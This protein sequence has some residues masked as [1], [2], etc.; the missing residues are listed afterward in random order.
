MG[1]GI[2]SKITAGDKVTWRDRSISGIDSDTGKPITYTPATHSLQYVIKGPDSDSLT[3]AAVVDGQEWVTTIAAAQS[4]QLSAGLYFWSAGV[5][6]GSGDRVTIQTGQIKVAVNLATI[7]APYDGRSNSRKMLEAVDAAIQARLSGGAVD[8]YTIKGR[9]ASRTPIPDLIRLRDLLK[10][11]VAREDQAA[12]VAQ[13][14]V[15]PGKLF[16]RFGGEL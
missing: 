13:G 8:S 14:D 1:L 3:L 9:D 12:K 10:A 11:E 15:A 5:I 4:A 2:P 7:A 6:D 16:V